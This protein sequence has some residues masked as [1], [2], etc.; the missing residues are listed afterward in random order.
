MH[1]QTGAS[2][3]KAGVHGYNTSSGYGVYGL[4]VS[5]TGVRGIGQ[6]RGVEGGS[7]SGAGVFGIS[8]ATDEAGVSGQNNDYAGV[9]G[10]GFYGVKGVSEYYGVHGTASTFAGVRGEGTGFAKGGDFYNNTSDDV[11]PALKATYN[12]GGNGPIFQLFEHSNEKFSVMR[13]GDV[14]V[15]GGV[16]P[17]HDIAETLIIAEMDIEAG[18]VVIADSNLQVKKCCK[19]YD[20]ALVGVV[21]TKPTITMGDSKTDDGAPKKPIALTGIVPTKVDANFGEV[22]I[23]D[24]LTTSNTP[25]YAMKVT[26]KLTAV[27]A[28]VGKALEPLASGKG[29]IMVLVTLQ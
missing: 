20:S 11:T 21:S 26:D 23:G 29:K 12:G 13:N 15:K 16:T 28:I 3:P 7:Q 2:A 9:Y 18:D 19:A 6:I 14:Y 4:S 25:G 17:V 22:K 1:G 27:G 10:T 8:E 24:L 5:G